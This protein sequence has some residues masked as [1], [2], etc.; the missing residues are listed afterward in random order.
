MVTEAEERDIDE[1]ITENF[2]GV[3]QDWKM[4]C[5]LGTDDTYVELA[6]RPPKEMRQYGKLRGF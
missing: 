2:P 1:L 5:L 4:S 6:P 3:V